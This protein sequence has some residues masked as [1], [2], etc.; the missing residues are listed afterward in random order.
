LITQ[1]KTFQNNGETSITGRLRWNYYS[2]FD[3]LWQEIVIQTF[4]N[5]AWAC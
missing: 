1:R 3:F 4:N 5:R 2:P